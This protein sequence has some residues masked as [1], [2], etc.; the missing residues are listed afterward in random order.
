MARA[1][2]VVC[3]KVIG[4]DPIFDPLKPGNR[5]STDVHGIR[6]KPLTCTNVSTWTAKDPQSSF[7]TEEVTG[8]NPVSRTN[9]CAGQRPYPAEAGCG[10]SGFGGVRPSS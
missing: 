1:V 10:F 3:S 9:V 5:R 7:H 6:Y 4:V 2:V 8:S